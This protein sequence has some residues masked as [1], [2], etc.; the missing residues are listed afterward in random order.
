MIPPSPSYLTPIADSAAIPIAPASAHFLPGLPQNAQAGGAT[1]LSPRAWCSVLGPSALGARSRGA[2]SR[3]ARSS[4][5]AMPGPAVPIAIILLLQLR[6]LESASDVTVVCR[7]LRDVEVTWNPMEH[8]GANLSLTWRPRPLQALSPSPMIP[9]SPRSYSQEPWRPCPLYFLFGGV[10][11]GCV[12]PARRGRPLE[13][14]VRRGADPVYHWKG[15]AS[16][17]LKPRP[18]DDLA[19]HWLED[20]VRVTCSV[21]PHVGLDYVIQH[22]GP[23][24]TDWVVSCDVI[25]SACSMDGVMSSSQHAMGPELHH[26]VPAC[27]EMGLMSSHYAVGVEMTSSGS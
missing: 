21:L 22:R 27:T 12:L 10:T 4:V 20:A 18:P 23:S 16:A 15:L 6:I 5:P 17:F 3:G 26:R 11:S 9:G 25:F 19:L 13:I 14:D 24:D 2:R 7:D 8:V 1:E